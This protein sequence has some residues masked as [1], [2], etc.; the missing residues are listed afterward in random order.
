M[1]GRLIAIQLIVQ[2]G[3]SHSTQNL[4][5]GQ[6]YIFEGLGPTAGAFGYFVVNKWTG[7]VWDL[8]DCKQIS[9]PA[10]KAAQAKLRLKFKLEEQAEYDRLNSIKPECD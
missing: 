9:T 4:K 3:L 6:F 7:A 5:K 10:S 1:L 8:W 2:N